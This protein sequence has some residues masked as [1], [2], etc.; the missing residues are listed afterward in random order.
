MSDK[1]ELIFEEPPPLTRTGRPSKY[2]PWL[3]K[4]KQHPGVWAK[5][6]EEVINP[7][8]TA[9]SIR[10]GKQTPAGFEIVARSSV[11]GRNKGHI[12]ARYVGA[13]KASA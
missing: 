7:S 11:P 3:A 8:A 4:L 6:P 5:Y 2:G 10:R 13:K 1:V 9:Y 12:Y